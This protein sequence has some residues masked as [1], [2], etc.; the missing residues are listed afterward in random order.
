M[1]T[2]QCA[3]HRT[4]GSAVPLDERLLGIDPLHAAAFNVEFLQRLRWRDLPTGRS[5]ARE[6][7]RTMSWV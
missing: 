7:L 3:T 6:L 5:V 1:G 2:I 4:Q